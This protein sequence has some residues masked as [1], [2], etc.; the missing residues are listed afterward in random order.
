MSEFNRQ[1]IMLAK[2]Y[3]HIAIGLKKSGYI[4]QDYVNRARVLINLVKNDL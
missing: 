3:I 1:R 4:Y 2:A